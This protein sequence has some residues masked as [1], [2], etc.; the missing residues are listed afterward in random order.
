MN[1]MIKLKYFAVVI[2]L[3]VVTATSCRDESLYPL[4]YAEK[5]FAGYIRIIKVTSNVIDL[6]NVAESAFEAELEAVDELNG[7]NLQEIE[8][9]VSH[10]RG[11]GLTNEV[12]FTTV[13]GAEFSSVPGPTISIFK[14]LTVRFPVQN[15]IS[16]LQ[17]LNVDPD[18]AGGLV[19]FP[20]GPLLAA[21]QIIIRWVMVLKDGKRFSVLNPQASVNAS[22]AK[23][24]EA[25]TTAN[26]TGGQFYSSPFIYTL[27]VRPLIAGS[28]LGTYSLAQTA[29]WS[30]A[31]TWNQ[32]E[33]YPARLNEV[34]FPNQTVTLTTVPGGLSTERQFT[35]TYRGQTTTLKINLENGTVFVPLQN[36]AITCAPDKSLFWTTP[37]TGN[38]TLGT[39]GALAPGLPQV[40][41]ANRGVYSA[42]STGLTAGN[43]LIIGLDDDA[44]EYGLRNG[45]CSWTR[46]VKLLLTKL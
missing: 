12:L 14:R 36:S 35:V 27:T 16:A 3:L 41:T 2:A 29:I 21:D 46:R 15:I 17:T 28:W 26:V 23:T 22:F 43:T 11:S 32:H 42:A 39:F 18:G 30:P 37:T 5:N 6:N 44:D 10:R 19:A 4:P 34:L 24:A 25:N 1:I 31:H 40:T 20:G 9:Y 33:F 45:Y 8:F 13:S 7:D 38:F